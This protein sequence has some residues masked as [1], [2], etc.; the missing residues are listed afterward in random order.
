[1]RNGCHVAIT[2]AV[3]CLTLL[4]VLPEPAVSQDATQ[5]LLDE[6]SRRSGLSREE[7]L[8]R[9]QEKTGGGID[10][11]DTPPG[12]TELPGAAGPSIRP[13]VI[14]PF[15]LDLAA[16]RKDTTAHP[17]PAAALPDSIFGADFFRLD[18]G[19]FAPAIFGPVPE[20]Y[21]LGVGDQV[22]VDVWGEVEFR[23]ERV[24]DRD[25]AVILPKG[26]KIRCAGRTLGEVA[27]AVR[28][29]LS[30]SYSG[31]DTKGE[32]GTTF[33]DVSLGRLRAIR[34]FV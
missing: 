15:D 3:A 23:L 31:I 32:G 5:D 4:A 7:L 22:F 9:Y 20:G 18:T 28:E 19:V 17:S 16:A 10:D 21:Q 34:V 13:G 33:V 27:R 26:G 29:K 14:L 24:V 11:E 25:G 1:M 2:L 30:G 12:L 8:R 6:A